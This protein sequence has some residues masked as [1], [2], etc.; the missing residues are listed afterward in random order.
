MTL[1]NRLTE[2]IQACFSGIWIVSYEHE[3]AL[4]EIAALCRQQ[5]WQLAVWDVDRGLH[6]PGQPASEH[7]S[8][9]SD[10]LAAI[11]SFGSMSAATLLVASAMA[12]MY[13]SRAASNCLI[14]SSTC[15]VDDV[16]RGSL[17]RHPPIMAKHNREV[18][19]A[20][21]LVT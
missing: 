21:V 16:A 11:R 2:L 20:I 10:P 19:S 6:V 1:T 3:D 5:E 14:N 4:A 17:R 13:F 9:G 7:E 15:D 8:A 12:D 18:N